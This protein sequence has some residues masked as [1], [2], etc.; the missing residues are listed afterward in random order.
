MYFF[1]V[2]IWNRLFRAPPLTSK[3]FRCPTEI[4]QYKFKQLFPS[5]LQWA[6]NTAGRGWERKHVLCKGKQLLKRALRGETVESHNKLCPYMAGLFLLSSIASRPWGQV[7][8]WIL[9]LL[10]GSAAK[11]W[12][13]E[14]PIKIRQTWGTEL[15][16]EGSADGSYY[17][18][19]LTSS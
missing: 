6:G 16:E 17:L 11:W 1:P 7:T 5:F 8:E 18:L 2:I 14:K 4:Q 10:L 19:R 12:E 3:I 13:A 9:L 15:T